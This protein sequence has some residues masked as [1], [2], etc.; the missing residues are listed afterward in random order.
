MPS[1]SS[2]LAETKDDIY[3]ADF[4]DERLL[5]GGFRLQLSNSLRKV[6]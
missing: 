2:A 6:A 3:L 5:L 1:Y 4:K